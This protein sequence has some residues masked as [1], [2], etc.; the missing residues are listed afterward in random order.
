MLI[1]MRDGKTIIIK[2]ESVAEL[3]AIKDFAGG[4]VEIEM[5]KPFTAN[6]EVLVVTKPKPEDSKNA[7]EAV[8]K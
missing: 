5:P 1:E 6:V 2:P 7:R 4:A 8:S 3:I